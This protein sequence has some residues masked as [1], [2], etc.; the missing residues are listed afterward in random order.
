MLAR[1][2]NTGRNGANKKIMAFQDYVDFAERVYRSGLKARD[3]DVT[4]EEIQEFRKKIR[5]N[6][7]YRFDIAT[8]IVAQRGFRSGGV[9]DLF[10]GAEYYDPTTDEKIYEFG[11]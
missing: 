4:E 5:K 3:I 10:G 1:G 9:T 2:F 8:A 6:E 11:Q 7:K